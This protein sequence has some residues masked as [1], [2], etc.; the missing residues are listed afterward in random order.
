MLQIAILT[1]KKWLVKQHC[2]MLQTMKTLQHCKLHHN[3][4]ITC[5][6]FIIVNNIGI[7]CNEVYMVIHF[8]LYCIP[9]SKFYITMQKIK[10]AGM[11]SGISWFHFKF[12]TVDIPCLIKMEISF[13]SLN[14]DFSD[15]WDICHTFLPLSLQC[16]TF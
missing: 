2:N 6:V 14:N 11:R 12:S 9:C 8:G 13:Q 5:N 3:I 10:Q 4:V 7:H 1:M 16:E 15:K